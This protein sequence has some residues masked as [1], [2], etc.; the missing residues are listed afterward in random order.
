MKTKPHVT[1]NQQINEETKK[2]IRKHL[3]TNEKKNSS[4][5]PTQYSKSS[6]K[7]E[8]YTDTVLSQEIKKSQINN[9]NYHLKESDKRRTSKTQ[10]S[11]RNAIITFREDIK[12]PRK[13]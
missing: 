2:E 7:T 8:V 12:N 3:E 4:P 10:S 11:R 1:K 9:P 13:Q 5:K 6:L